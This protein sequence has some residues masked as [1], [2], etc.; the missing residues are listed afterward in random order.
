MGRRALFAAFVGFAFFVPA[1]GCETPATS[2]PS[3]PPAAKAEPQTIRVDGLVLVSTASVD[4]T[5]RTAEHLRDRLKQYRK[6]LPPRAEKKTPAGDE[7]TVRLFGTSAA[8]RSAAESRGLRIDNPACYLWESREILLGFDGARYDDV[9]AAAEERSA[10]LKQQRN[11]AA[12]QFAAAQKAEEQRFRAENVAAQVRHDL[13]Q[14]RKQ[15][16]QRSNAAAER[17]RLEAEEKNEKLFG[18][19]TARLLALADHELFHAY[20]HAEVYSQADAGLPAWLDE[21]LAQLAE[22]A[23]QRGD[24][25]V[26]DVPAPALVQSLRLE[27]KQG[28]PPTVAEILASTDK[29]YLVADRRATE[30]VRRRYLF[31]WALAQLLAETKRLTPRDGLDRYVVDLHH[32]PSAAFARLTRKSPAEF[33]LEWREFLAKVVK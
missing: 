17:E 18:E 8:Y 23:R 16:F 29:H 31:A 1:Q 28:E 14:R 33:E 4:V 9:L 25:L 27:L 22:N 11:A 3:A 10:K 15:A 21:G 6:F 30:A 26:V 12:R 19:A 32:D 24:A 2:T 5:N 13:S 7:I 20:V